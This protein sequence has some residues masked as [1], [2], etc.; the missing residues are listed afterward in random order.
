MLRM[1]DSCRNNA[2]RLILVSLVSSLIGVFLFA[3]RPQYS[4]DSRPLAA[5]LEIAEFSKE[6]TKS[7]SFDAAQ[8]SSAIE[9]LFDRAADEILSIEPSLPVLTACHLPQQP[10]GP[11]TCA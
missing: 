6:A 7:I 1:T 10:R 5:V 9:S 8:I 2:V 4:S 3:D 11:P